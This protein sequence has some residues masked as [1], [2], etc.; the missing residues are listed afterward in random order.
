M[1]A[2]L[3]SWVEENLV[4]TESLFSLVVFE[5]SVPIVSSQMEENH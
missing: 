4:E 5:F 1:H 3:G 2:G